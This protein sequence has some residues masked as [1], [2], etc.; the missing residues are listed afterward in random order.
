MEHY[1][2]PRVSDLSL[3]LLFPSFS[4]MHL[5]TLMPT[6]ARDRPA[7]ILNWRYIWW[8]SVDNL[9]LFHLSPR[10]THGIKFSPSTS[11]HTTILPAPKHASSRRRLSATYSTHSGSSNSTP[12][13]LSANAGPA[14]RHARPHFEFARRGRLVYLG[15]VSAYPTGAVAQTVSYPFEVLRGECTQ[16]GRCSGHV[17]ER[18][19]FGTWWATGV[20]RWN[21]DW[22]PCSA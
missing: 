22:I 18:P 5:Q 16:P 13:A 4:S 21:E 20:F 10:A 6:R 11:P 14:H 19:L 3:P 7:P 15:T 8:P 1:G 2:F 17:W 9:C 12:S